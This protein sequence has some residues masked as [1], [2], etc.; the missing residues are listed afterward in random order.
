MIKSPI[1]SVIGQS[2]KDIITTITLAFNILAGNI[3]LESIVFAENDGKI[4]W[5]KQLP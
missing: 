5:L 1:V 3:E 2:L 4:C